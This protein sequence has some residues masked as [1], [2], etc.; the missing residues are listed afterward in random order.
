[1]DGNR[2]TLEFL[3]E[4]EQINV[5]RSVVFETPPRP[6]PHA[7]DWGRIEGMMLGLAVGDALGNTSEG[8]NPRDRTARYGEI[9]DYLP[10]RHADGFSI[11]LPS[12]DTQL[13]FWTLEQMIADCGFDAERVSARFCQRPIFGIGS[14]VSHFIDNMESGTK[15][16]YQC[17]KRS[18]GN[19]ALMRIAPMIIPHLE[20]ATAD[21][22]VDTALS[23]MITHNDSASIAACVSFVNLLWKLVQMASPPDPWWWL[24]TYV[25]MAKALEVVDT[26][27]QRS[28]SFPNYLGTLWRF[29]EEQVAKAY[30]KKSSVLEAC[31]SW[32]SGA[33]LLETVPN[34]IYILMRH[35]RDPEEAMVRA[36]ND[37]RDNDTVAAVVGAA[38]GAL[39][40]KAG[41]PKRWL[42]NLS[43]RTS[44]SDDGRVFELLQEARRI[45]GRGTA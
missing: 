6:K 10:N 19:G 23:A 9:R 22:W 32:Y 18:A 30:V 7:V 11:G 28:A 43:G 44:A 41:L 40:G 38:I 42:S 45:W 24:E 14:T 5:G 12:D 39:H 27:R 15:A 35:G 2:Q 37:T 21:L 29:V 31:N 13:A 17:G 16:W 26:Y 36:V 34:V 20:T 33:Y 3:F 4:T 25:E 8:Q 1:M